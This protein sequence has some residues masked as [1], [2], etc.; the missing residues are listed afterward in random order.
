[1]CRLWLFC[2]VII[3]KFK[4]YILSPYNNPYDHTMDTVVSTYREY[5]NPHNYSCSDHPKVN[6]YRSHKTHY[7]WLWNSSSSANVAMTATLMESRSWPRIQSWIENQMLMY[8]D[9]S[10]PIFSD[11]GI[12]LLSWVP[13][14]GRTARDA[15]LYCCHYRFHVIALNLSPLSAAVTAFLLSRDSVGTCARIWFASFAVISVPYSYIHTALRT[16]WPS[17]FS[18]SSFTLAASFL[19]SFRVS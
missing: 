10:M 16:Y 13:P 15:T 2:K 1:M 9:I 11:K 8:T 12:Q 17:H 14:M 5:P 6:K 3:F 7:L 18:S 4:S 19:F